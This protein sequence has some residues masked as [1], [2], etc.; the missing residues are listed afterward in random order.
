M[1]KVYIVSAVRTPIGKFG[2]VLSS[3]A[4]SKLGAIVIKEAL[5][6]GNVPIEQVSEVLMGCVLQAGLGQM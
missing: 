5:R 3:I 6:R 4:P 2:G 1:E